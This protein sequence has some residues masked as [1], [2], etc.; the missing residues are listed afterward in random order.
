MQLPDFIAVPALVC[1]CVISAHARA[2]TCGEF[3]GLGPAAKNPQDL[4]AHAASHAQVDVYR[5]MIADHAASI[6]FQSVTTR[7]RGLKKLR[8]SKDGLLPL[9]RESLALTRIACFESPNLNFEDTG[10]GEFNY[11]LDAWGK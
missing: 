10:K 2:M 4:I 6:A 1:S 11:L 7:A 3:N 8:N 9:V 5:K